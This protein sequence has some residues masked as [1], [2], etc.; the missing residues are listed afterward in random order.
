MGRAKVR[1]ILHLA[2]RLMCCRS[3]PR[4]HGSMTNVL[5]QLSNDISSIVDRAA[6]SVVQVYGRRRPFS[7]VVFGKGL[8][9]TPAHADEDAVSVRAGD[10]S[11]DG[12]VL[13]RVANMGLT[14]VRVDGLAVP[15]LDAAG[16]PKPGNLAIAIGRTWSGGVM[17]ALAA[18]SVV[19]GPLRTGRSA[20]IDRVIRIQQPP[21][22]AL[23]GGALVDAA[24]R[25]LG[26]ITVFAIRHTTVVI[27][28]SLAWAAGATTSQQ[29]GTRPG[30]L[31]V[32]SLAVELPERQRGGRA[33]EYGLLVSHVVSGSPAEAGGV[34][35]GDI[36]VGFGGE[37]LQEPE[38][39]VTRLRGGHV[40][41]PVP[42]TVIRG[43]S[44]QDVT[45]TPGER[46]SR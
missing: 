17:S 32:S 19:G 46:P 1:P 31:G 33:Q 35:V 44:V 41:K 12:A 43:T 18:V 7:G 9:L 40:G 16:E 4:Y 27:P 29:G 3:S 38:E 6:G 37:A 21:H 26:V 28:A 23:A 20:S 22:G 39:M 42:I 15:A 14:V 13:G 45:V 24:G 2:N 30:F 5:E 11:L 8:V 34:L 25:A 36:I 10:H